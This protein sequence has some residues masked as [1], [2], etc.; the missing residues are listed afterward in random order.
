MLIHLHRAN[1]FS[2]RDY[3]AGP[4]A[5][6]RAARDAYQALEALLCAE[7]PC[8]GTIQEAAANFRGELVTALKTAG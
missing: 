3:F 6:H 2:L 8:R 1:P 7:S 5:C 4:G